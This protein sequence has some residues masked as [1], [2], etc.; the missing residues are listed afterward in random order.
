MSLRV[1]T[2]TL[3]ISKQHI[4]G[5]EICQTTFFGEKCEGILP[6]GGI[7]VATRLAWVASLSAAITKVSVPRFNVS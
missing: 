6:T 1:Q 2:L 4:W 5:F 7:A 3:S